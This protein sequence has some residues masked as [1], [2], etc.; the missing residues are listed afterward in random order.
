MRELNKKFNIKKLTCSREL[1]LVVVLIVLCA[2][3]QFRNSSFLTFGTMEAMLK[4]YS[5]TMILAL[6]MLGVLL[7]GGIDISIGSTLAFSG[8]TAALLMRDGVF[9][10]TPLGFLASMLVGGA[11]GF[12]IGLIISKGKVLPII[13]T[14]G[15]MNIVRGATYIIADSRWVAAYE[16]PKKFKDFATSSYLG[17][18]IINNMIAVMLFCY[19][20]FFI[21]MKWTRIGRK[22]Y[23]V[24]S[25][26]EAAQVSGIKIDNIKLMVYTVM[27]VIS[28]LAGALWVSIYASAQGNMADGIE[29][30]V[31]A[32][33][34]IGGVSLNGGRGS[35]VGVFLGGII[36]SI[37]GKALP[38]IH[39]DQ[40]WQKAV[41]GLIILIA[42]IINVVTQRVVEKNNLK[43]REL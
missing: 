2:A 30:D 5:V 33:C 25:N 20:I 14:L 31:I 36:M 12:L 37:I 22:V 29:M 3:I 9:T 34:V 17:L 1:S 8:M 15:F 26:P 18:G 28:G 42:I 21:V 23:A 7:I 38:L 13:A 11:W 16:I 10:A 40:F 41:K 43:R 24:G 19:I 35:V 39:V 6:G 32:A 27:G 4:N